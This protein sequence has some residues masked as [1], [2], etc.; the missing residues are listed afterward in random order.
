MQ[1]RPLPRFLQ[2]DYPSAGAWF[3]NF[4]GNLNSIIDTIN[5]LIQSGIDTFY[6]INCERQ[7]VTLSHN[8]PIQ[9]TLK[10]LDAIPRF[11][12]VGYAA[13]YIGVGAITSYNTNGTFM[14]T[15]YFVGTA[16]TAAVSTMLIFEP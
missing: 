2:D 12:R 7:T 3:Y 8:T 1:I 16:P 10:T 15:V 14:V 5:P 6:N 13:G 4:L 9:I 11:V